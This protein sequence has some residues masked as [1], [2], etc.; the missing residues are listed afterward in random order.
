[1]SN[2]EKICSFIVHLNPKISNL[3]LQKLLYYIQAYSLIT[4]GVPAFKNKIEAW[5]YG[6]VVPEVYYNFKND[7]NKYKNNSFQKLDS[8]ISNI[9]KIIVNNLGNL[10]P[11]E[12]VRKTHTYDT[13]INAWNN[14]Y[15]KE[16]TV[17]S[18]FNYHIGRYNKHMGV[19]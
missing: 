12:L 6:P 15:D 18:I 16:I 3:A 14:P 19:F 4:T 11:F 2:L 9:V 17:S 5:T 1:M 10:D 7:P 13:W 8:N